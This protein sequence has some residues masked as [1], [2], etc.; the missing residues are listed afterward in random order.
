MVIR[1]PS[2]QPAS[3]QKST[4]VDRRPISPSRYQEN[5]P[6]RK[7]RWRLVRTSETAPNFA[8]DRDDAV[9]LECEKTKRQTIK[10][11][12]VQVHAQAAQHLTR[13]AR[14]AVPERRKMSQN[15]RL[16]PHRPSTLD[17]NA[18]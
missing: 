1:G 18:S 6:P 17:F 15:V 4:I 9:L 8:K 12:R 14:T 3:S 16:Q 7:E 10:N 2:S 11:R 5:Y 13:R